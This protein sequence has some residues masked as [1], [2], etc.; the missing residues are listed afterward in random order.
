M[1]ALA[2]AEVNPRDSFSTIYA[3][4]YFNVINQ[5]PLFIIQMP[6]VLVKNHNYSKWPP[7]YNDSYNILF[8]LHRASGCHHQW[9]NN[10]GWGDF[11]GN[12]MCPETFSRSLY[13]G[14]STEVLDPQELWRRVLPELN[15][16]SSVQEDLVMIDWINSCIGKEIK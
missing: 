1:H 12:Q 8:I 4:M 9:Q 13:Q 15:W 11:G 5:I 7:H 6:N 3:L 16:S 10:V 2:M 14:V